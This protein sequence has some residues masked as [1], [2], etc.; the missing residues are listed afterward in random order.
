[1]KPF[2]GPVH[3]EITDED[4][5]S[6]PSTIASPA[7]LRNDLDDLKRTAN[8]FGIVSTILLA[9]IIIGV[10]LHVVLALLPSNGPA[11]PQTPNTI[12]IA[13]VQSISRSPDPEPAAATNTD[14]GPN[15]EGT[16]P[17]DAT[18]EPNS[19]V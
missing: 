12:H 16:V 4:I 7:Q 9:P 18:G 6:I 10:Y 3:T 15:D 2:N 11:N 5:G 19:G 17:L 13:P 1:S 14:K 8:I